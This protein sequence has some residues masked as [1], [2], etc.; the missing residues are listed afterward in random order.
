MPHAP[1]PVISGRPRTAVHRRAEDNA[2]LV[3]VALRRYFPQLVGE[4]LQ[5]AY[6]EGLLGLLGAAE[7][8]DPAK[9]FAFSTYAVTCIHLTIARHLMGDGG[10]IHE[11]MYVKEAALVVARAEARLHRETGLGPGDAEILARCGLAPALAR[12]GL[13]S[14]R[15]PPVLSLEM[16]LA[17]DSDTTLGDQLRDDRPGPEAALLAREDPLAPW[18]S[19]LADTEAAALRA[20]CGEDE[21][22][23]DVARQWGVSRQRIK[24]LHD[25]GLARLRAQVGAV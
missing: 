2:A 14:H 21:S 5:D 25:R 9:G 4:A 12:A 13:R 15:R 24:Q 11:P 10:P 20:C 16:P 19:G 6:T 23:A 1:L 17:E 7:R 8:F 22:M 18:L 3:G